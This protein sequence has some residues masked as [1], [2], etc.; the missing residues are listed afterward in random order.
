MQIRLILDNAMVGLLI[1]LMDFIPILLAF[2]LLWLVN[3]YS[4]TANQRDGYLLAIL[5]GLV[6]LAVNMKQKREDAIKNEEMA[7]L[8]EAADAHYWLGLLGFALLV[9]AIVLLMLAFK[10][11]RTPTRR[12]N[13][14]N[15]STNA[16]SLTDSVASRPEKLR[17]L[18][19][20]E[21]NAKQ[22]TNRKS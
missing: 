6:G 5:A 21:E 14:E 13:A 3:E 11:R 4:S 2:G 16:E 17:L 19:N 7:R 1:K 22:I 15:L 9:F 20:P 8:E 18:P 10:R 12:R